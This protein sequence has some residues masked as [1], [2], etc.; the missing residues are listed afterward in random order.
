MALDEGKNLTAFEQKLGWYPN[1]DW[2][3]KDYDQ[4]CGTKQW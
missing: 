1:I 2:Y 4:E 3:F